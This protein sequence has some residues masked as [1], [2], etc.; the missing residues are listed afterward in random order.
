MDSNYNNVCTQVENVRDGFPI[1]RCN[2]RTFTYGF[3]SLLCIMLTLMGACGFLAT[4]IA[5][6]TEGVIVTYFIL[7]MFWVLAVVFIALM[8]NPSVTMYNR[9]IV[10]KNIWGK[11]DAYYYEQIQYYRIVHFPL[12]P[13][14]DYIR[15]H[16]QGKYICYGACVRN[17]GKL[18]AFFRNTSI[19]QK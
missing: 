4:M 5:G 3:L 18:C 10:C 13:S 8:V 7:S 2:Y 16:V 17:Y 11:E 9:G 12:R 14:R 1:L 15:I 6:D 19:P